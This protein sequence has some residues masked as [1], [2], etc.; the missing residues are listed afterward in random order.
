[1]LEYVYSVIF[2]FLGGL[3]LRVLYICLTCLFLSSC[4]ID[5]ISNQ[6]NMIAK[7]S[8]ANPGCKSQTV[9]YQGK[10][11]H[12]T[13]CIKKLPFKPSKFYVKVGDKVI[14]TGDDYKGVEFNSKYKSQHLTGGCISTIILSTSANKTIQYSKLPS[15]LIR[16]CNI[17]RLSNGQSSSFVK[18]KRCDKVF[19][20][21]ILPLLGTVYPTEIA[22]QCI[23]KLN[24]STIYKQKFYW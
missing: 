15:D 23:I 2:C 20:D 14:Y 21:K 5:H 4:A 16:A 3:K 18:T 24:G 9:N 10:P 8:R 12:S 7:F 11:L 19:Y 17:K 22:K 6:D 13:V 1:M